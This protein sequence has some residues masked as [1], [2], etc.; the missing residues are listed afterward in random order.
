VNEQRDGTVPLHRAPADRP[1]VALAA[2][3][4]SLADLIARAGPGGTVTIPDGLTRGAAP[5]RVTASVRLVSPTGAEVPDDI[6][7]IGPAVLS[8]S[9]I[10]TTGVLTASPG[11][12]LIARD[13][14]FTATSGGTA[15]IGTGAGCALELI[16]CRFTGAEGSAVR[17]RSGATA[18]LT[19]CDFVSFQA[20]AVAVSDPATGVEV[21]DCRFT[22]MTGHAV[23]A[24]GG[25]SARVAGCSFDGFLSERWTAVIAVSAGSCVAVTG[26][27]FGPMTAHGVFARGGSRARIDDCEFTGSADLAAVS[28]MDDDSALEVA[29][30]RFTGITGRGVEVTD[31]ATAGISDCDLQAA[32]DLA[33]VYAEGPGSAVSLAGCRISSSNALGVAAAGGAELDVRDS[34]LDCP[35]AGGLSGAVGLGRDGSRLRITGTCGLRGATLTVRGTL[36][37]REAAAGASVTLTTAAS[38]PCPPCNG[39]GGRPGA[40][41]TA[42]PR[43]GGRAAPGLVDASARPLDGSRHEWGSPCPDCHGS[44]LSSTDPCPGCDGRGGPLRERTLQINIP[45]G[46]Q[47]GHTLIA[48]G[49][50][51]DGLGSGEPGDL[52]IV[53]SVAD[54]PFRT[55]EE[56]FEKALGVQVADGAA[57]GPAPTA[58]APGVSPD[59]A[60]REL[61]E[62]VRREAI[63]LGYLP[64]DGSDDGA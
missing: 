25:A 44:G 2:E 31:G 7:V 3:R 39:S 23:L 51:G 27:R 37:H 35:G 16:E 17:L 58:G 36:D 13:C 11:A 1:T 6:V 20:P 38:A 21:T 47:S 59:E 4:M 14:R 19:E 56:F 41:L 43:C 32:G 53:L 29:D 9:G 18:R 12:R 34:L 60:R 64:A 24:E 22:G 8:L 57:S 55:V 10:T 42:C 46:V 33:P 26:C 52:H 40:D 61:D 62:A 15:V 45:A 54:P 5:V 30:C 50:G 48:A 28:A 49:H 63:R